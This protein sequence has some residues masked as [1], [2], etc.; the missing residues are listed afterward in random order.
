MTRKTR[1]SE[2][3]NSKPDDDTLTIAAGHVRALTFHAWEHES[4]RLQS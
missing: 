4:A 3:V 1:D 2:A